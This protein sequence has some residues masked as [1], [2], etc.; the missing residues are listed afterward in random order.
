MYRSAPHQQGSG[1][2]QIAGDVSGEDIPEG[3]K[4]AEVYTVALKAETAMP[5]ALPL[6]PA[7]R[8]RGMKVSIGNRIHGE[9][10]SEFG[11]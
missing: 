1:H 3:I 8:A 2:H 6:S 11:M 7:R 10:R 9:I 4:T 5:S